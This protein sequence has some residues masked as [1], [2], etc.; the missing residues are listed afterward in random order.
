[1]NQKEIEDIVVSSFDEVFS[2]W[3]SKI[4]KELYPAA[5][6]NN[7]SWLRVKNAVMINNEYLQKAISTSLIKVIAELNQQDK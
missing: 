6:A 2:N 1:M 5:F 4:E 3:K 7:S